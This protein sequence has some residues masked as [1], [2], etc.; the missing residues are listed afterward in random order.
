MV[1]R[2]APW[3]GSQA[4]QEGF[5]EA[6]RVT[7]GAILQA[8]PQAPLR[9]P[10]AGGAPAVTPGG[11]SRLTSSPEACCAPERLAL[12]SRPRL[13][14]RLGHAGV[15]CSASRVARVGGCNMWGLLGGGGILRAP[16]MAV[17]HPGAGSGWTRQGRRVERV[18]A[19]RFETLVE[20]APLRLAR[21]GRRRRGD[22]RHRGC[23]AACCPNRRGSPAGDGPR[24]PEGFR[25]PGRG[26]HPFSRPKACAVGAS[27]RQRTGGLW[28]CGRPPGCDALGGAHAAG[29]PPGCPCGRL[30]RPAP[31]DGPRAAA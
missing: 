2:V 16:Y 1:P 5:R 27:V 21:P 22:P 17:R 26:P 24:G 8:G 20:Q 25:P 11:H 18:C 13:A 7:L 19:H 28:A 15:S 12:R 10:H 4:Q 23:P 14:E 29:W 3:T 9:L 30:R 31:G 6:P